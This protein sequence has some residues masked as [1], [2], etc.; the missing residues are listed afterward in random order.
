MYTV[1]REYHDA[2]CSPSE[3]KAALSSRKG[4]EEELAGRLLPSLL[5][6]YDTLLRQPDDASVFS[7]TALH[8]RETPC[9]YIIPTWTIPRGSPSSCTRRLAG[10]PSVSRQFGEQ[11]GRRWIWRTDTAVPRSPAR[12]EVLRVSL[13]SSFF[14]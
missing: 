14:S 5:L 6:E 3:S 2:A 1:V 12:T 13:L 7:V 11:I 9:S 4:G 10:E 8:E